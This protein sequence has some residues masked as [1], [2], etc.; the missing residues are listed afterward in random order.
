[1]SFWQTK[2]AF[3]RIVKT[4]VAVEDLVKQLSRIADLLEHRELAKQLA[5]DRER[6]AAWLLLGEPAFG[7][8]G[9]GSLVRPEVLQRLAL[10]IKNGRAAAWVKEH[11]EVL[12]ELQRALES[13]S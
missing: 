8:E 2:E 11:P 10:A 6:T 5:E 4:L 9:D 12:A 3:E 7:E 13:A 1:M